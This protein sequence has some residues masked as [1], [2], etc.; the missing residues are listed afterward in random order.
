MGV[1][2]GAGDVGL[3]LELGLGVELGNWADGDGSCE[4]NG[5]VKFPFEGE[6][7]G[8]VEGVVRAVSRM[9]GEGVF[10]AIGNEG[11]NEGR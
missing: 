2:I 5:D 9:N 8:A 4:G 11:A 3:G 10:P 6:L 7:L 1:A